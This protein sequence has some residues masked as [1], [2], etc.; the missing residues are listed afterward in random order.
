MTGNTRPAGTSSAG[1]D[2][3]TCLAETAARLGATIHPHDAREG[4]GSRGADSPGRQPLSYRSSHRLLMMR[5]LSSIEA[6]NIVAYVA[7]LHAAES[8]W[9]IRQVEQLV[10]LRAL[11]AC[12]MI[13]R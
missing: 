5:G 10:A 2:R 3:R 8:G 9:T 12:E 11:A 4:T 7:G 1:G 6:A 13:A